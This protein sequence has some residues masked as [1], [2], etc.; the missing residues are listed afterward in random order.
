MMTISELLASLAPAEDGFTATIPDT[1]RQGRTAFGGLSA[2]FCVEAA[3]RALPDLPPLRSAQFSFIGPAAGDVRVTATTLRRGR[4]TVF[5][6][7]DLFGE[8]G[9]ALHGTLCFGGARAS[10]LDY[11]QLPAPAAP[12]PDGL[13]SLFKYEPT[14]FHQNFD[15]LDASGGDRSRPALRLWLRHRDPA[16]PATISALIAL[17]DAPPPSALFYAKQ[18]GPLSTMT[19]MVDVLAHP[20]T[21]A[22]GWWLIENI[23]ETVAD[24]YSAQGTTLWNSVGAPVL[25]A[26]QNVAVFF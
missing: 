12:K 25:V 11:A 1:W 16:P 2:A 26:R 6:G 17:A 13:P 4:S 19:W 23:A 9:L 15:V 5:V 20:P 21:S 8:D 7:V 3:I 14:N 22:D 10:S 24:G 18:P